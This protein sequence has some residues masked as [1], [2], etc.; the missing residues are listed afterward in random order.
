MTSPLDLLKAIRS[1]RLEDVRAVFEAGGT[2]ESAEDGQGEPGLAMGI[3][4]FLG[5]PD[6]VRELVERGARVNL[7][8]N[9]QPTSPL[10]MAIRGGHSK[11][12]QTLIEL[13]ALVP[14]GMHTG[15]SE[16]EVT[17][18]QWIAFRDGYAAE[19][20]QGGDKAP[21]VE[22]IEVHRCSNVDTQVLEAEVL[23][24]A[25]SKL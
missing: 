2:L 14:E 25:M 22:E 9:T 12:V 19:S 8:D 17:V 23:R 21:V 3:A 18:A 6:I 11:V 16:R 20:V 7:P 24:E 5:H 4:C 15:L 1:G 10:S 13:G